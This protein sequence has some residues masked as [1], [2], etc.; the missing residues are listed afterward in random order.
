M[1]E[2]DPSRPVT[3]ALA[4]L[5]A[6]NPTGLADLLDVVGYNYQVSQFEK[7]FTAY[8]GRK[9]V[10]SE[11]G[12][13]MDAVEI[14]KNPRVAGEFLW[15]GFDFLGESGPWPSRGSAS[16]MFD[17]CG[18]LKPQNFLRVALWSEKPVVFLNVRSARGG[19]RGGRGG[20]F[21]GRGGG[22][23]GRGG[24]GGGNHWNWQ[25]D[26]RPEL[27]VDVYANCESVELF[28]NGQSLGRKPAVQSTNYVFNW[29]V[30]FQPGELKALGTRG[31]QTV[32]ARLVTAGALARV[33]LVAD[34]TQL[35]A[36]GRDVAHV[37]VRLVD[38][39]GVVVPNTNV[40]CTAKVGGA[41]RL[42]G[43]D[44]GDQSDM[45][46]LTSPTRNTRQGRALALV[47]SARKAGAITLT[48]S[49][50]GLPEAQLSLRAE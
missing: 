32:E 22:F 8:P 26:A 36:D 3:A 45:T 25:E 46:A 13:G 20:G 5:P 30:P 21:G 7:D 11:D 27:P 14:A 6:S 47:Q 24:G 48:V 44:N 4:N 43:L 16:G 15:V 19:G 50:P 34:R 1:H 49:A 39:K 17:T 12:F 37:E 29:N 28:L 41:G 23:G 2:C 35:A 10:G 42:L 9:F 18:F 38:A 31:G 40:F 33:E